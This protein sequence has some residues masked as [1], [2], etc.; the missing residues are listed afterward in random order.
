M[1]PTE[2]QPLLTF[3]LFAYNQERYI[4]EAVQGALRQTYFPLEIILSDDCSLDHTFEIMQAMAIRYQG[5]NQVIVRRN[6]KNLGLIGHINQVM[7]LVHGELIVAAAGD[8]ISFPDRV[9]RIYSE[10][11]LSGKKAYSIYSNAYFIQ[12]NNNHRDLVYKALPNFPHTSEYLSCRK[13]CVMGASHAWHPQLFSFFGPLEDDGIFEDVV[14]PFRAALLGEIRYIHEP[15]ILYRRHSENIFNKNI[16]YSI[17][18]TRE[19][20]K[21]VL[22]GYILAFKNR[23]SDLDRI[24]QKFPE[25]ESDIVK[26]QKNIK[27][28]ISD[29]LLEKKLYDVKLLKRV[30]L[31]LKSY[32]NG[33]PYFRIKEWSVMFIFPFLAFFITSMYI[34]YKN[35]TY[36][37]T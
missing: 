1:P 29:F 16:R 19:A 30:G 34:K 12:N 24:L 8:D 10:Y 21:R 36:G 22:P 4:A 27:Q 7:E 26:L 14:I 13:R 2:N 11:I 28:T 25:R 37:R 6:E 17:Q 35:M 23:L 33:T 9:E 15:L 5:Q 31:I 3:A 20:N 32:L 18:N